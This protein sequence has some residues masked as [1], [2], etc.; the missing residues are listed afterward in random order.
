MEY[1]TFFKDRIKHNG[2]Q[3]IKF[4]SF[5][6]FLRKEHHKDDGMK[7]IEL[8]NISRTFNSYHDHPIHIDE[9]LIMNLMK[10]IKDIKAH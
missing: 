5:I 2:E 4:D 3:F 6:D 10:D 1:P 7:T 8:Y 9:Q